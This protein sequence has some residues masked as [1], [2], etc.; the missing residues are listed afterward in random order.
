[1]QLP[2]II[3]S[4]FGDTSPIKSELAFEGAPDAVLDPSNQDPGNQPPW[5]FR[6]GAVVVAKAATATFVEGDDPTG[7]RNQPASVAALVAAD[8][9]WAGKTLEFSVSSGPLFTVVLAPT[10]NTDAL[11]VVALNNDGRFKGEL[12]ADEFNALLRIRTLQAGADKT[13][14]AN[15]QG[16]A[17][18][19]GPTGADAVGSDADY[20]VTLADGDLI[21]G[22]GAPASSTVACCRKGHFNTKKLRNLTAE[23]KVVLIRRGAFFD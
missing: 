6:A 7:D 5:R 13:V 15:V 1:V 8:A 19:F 17:T 12:V 16:L 4:I 3:L 23:A 9:T 18:A 22:S 10:D 2:G 20:R 11:V 14:H 21:D